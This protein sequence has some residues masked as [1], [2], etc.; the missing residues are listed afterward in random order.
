MELGTYLS[1]SIYFIIMLGIGLYAFK[2]N[3]DDASGYLLGG[4]KLSAPVTALSAGASDM[5]G[6]MLMGV[7]GAM[8]LSG[9]SSLWIAFGLILGAWINYL[10]VAP[11][12][13]VFT[14]V[15]NNSITIPDFFENR[16]SDDSRLL[17]VVGSLVIIM[18]FTLYTSS[19]VVAGGK[20]FVSSFGLSYE[21]GMYVTAGVVV[22]YT[23]FGGFAAVSI[24]DFIQGCIMF[25]ALVMVPSVVVFELGGI[26]QLNM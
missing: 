4:R 9:I 5:S 15:A 14:E 22:A 19:G 20:L 21:M 6:W 3:D 26:N 12:L 7:P 8:Y 18:F 1:L 25:I 17:R 23:F 16:F 2:T 13:R 10:V 24:T 11:R